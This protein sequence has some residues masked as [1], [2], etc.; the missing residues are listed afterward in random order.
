MGSVYKARDNELDRLVALKVI[1]PELTTNPEML[2]R[3]KQELILARQITHRNVVRIFDLGQ[4]DGFKF[5]TME[6]L[7]GKDLRAVLKEKGKPP[8]DE[9]ARI[10]LQIAPSSGQGV[11]GGASL[12]RFVLALG[13]GQAALGFWSGVLQGLP[14]DCVFF[15]F[16]LF[17]RL[18]EL[19]E[20]WFAHFLPLIL[21]E[22]HELVNL[23]VVEGIVGEPAIEFLFVE[24]GVV[25]F[26]AAHLVH[27]LAVDQRAATFQTGHGLVVDLPKRVGCLLQALHSANGFVDPVI[28]QVQRFVEMCF[29]HKQISSPRRNW[30]RVLQLMWRVGTH[31]SDGV[32]CRPGWAHGFSWTELRR[33]MRDAQRD[34][35]CDGNETEMGGLHPKGEPDTFYYSHRCL[36]TRRLG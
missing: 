4:A 10:I 30:P 2:R 11:R 15:F 7:E 19:D 26:L 18:Q 14:E 35:A 13:F 21:D 1:R 16:V 9:A 17:F 24:T 12:R 3:F 29:L 28:H 27:E 6:Y 33:G 22:S 23:L 31:V 36:L 8:P 5:I 34:G 32:E 25:L 20:G